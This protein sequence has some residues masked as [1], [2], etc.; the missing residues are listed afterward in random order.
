M[1]L[2]L[3]ASR[4]SHTNSIINKNNHTSPRSSKADHLIAVSALKITN[5]LTAAPPRILF[6]QHV[7]SEATG[8]NLPFAVSKTNPPSPHRR[9]NLVSPA[10]NV[11]ASGRNCVFSSPNS[12]MA[13]RK[14]CLLLPVLQT[15][16]RL[17]S[18]VPGCTRVWAQQWLDRAMSGRNNVWSQKCLDKEVIN[19][20]G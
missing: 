16:Q 10:H 18:S 2:T 12:P 8:P 4:K 7:S 15:P 19:L 14:W 6:A 1:L 20:V 5:P 3:N 13:V 11:S 17:D 9:P